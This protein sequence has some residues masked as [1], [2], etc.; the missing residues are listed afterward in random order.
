MASDVLHYSGSKI[1]LD[2]VKSIRD[3]VEK[4]HVGLHSFILLSEFHSV[5]FASNVLCVN[6]ANTAVNS[7]TIELCLE[8]KRGVDNV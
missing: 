1:L 4:N 7:S 6:S 3:I 2:P 8:L 5:L